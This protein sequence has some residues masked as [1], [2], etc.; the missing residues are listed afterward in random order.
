MLL[1]DKCEV[2]HIMRHPTSTHCVLC[3]FRTTIACVWLAGVMLTAQ[4]K[5]SRAE[6]ID[7]MCVCVDR[8]CFVVASA[9]VK[10]NFL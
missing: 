10:N 7:G 1:S 2:L 4:P 9:T 8:V 5:Q 6:Q 3:E